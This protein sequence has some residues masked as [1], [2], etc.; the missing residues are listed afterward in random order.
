MF[1]KILILKLHNISGIFDMKY[2][3][4]ASSILT[5]DDFFAYYIKKFIHHNSKKITSNNSIMIEF[6][7]S[8][9]C[10]YIF[11]GFLYWTF[12]DLNI[13]KCGSNMFFPCFFRG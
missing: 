3:S 10:E 2:L 6:L 8:Y 11:P 7:K 1:W 9:G 12:E 4:F 5:E 13:G